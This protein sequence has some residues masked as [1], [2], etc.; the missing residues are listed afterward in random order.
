[1][2]F[3]EEFRQLYMVRGKDWRGID[4]LGINE[5]PIRDNGLLYQGGGGGE[6]ASG[7]NSELC[8]R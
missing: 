2:A 3:L 6:G 8:R 4:L 5:N 1:M 7:Q